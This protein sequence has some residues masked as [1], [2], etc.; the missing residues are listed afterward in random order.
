LR[1][2]RTPPFVHLLRCGTSGPARRLEAHIEQQTVLELPRMTLSRPNFRKTPTAAAI[3]AGALVLGACSDDLVSFGPEDDPEIQ[4]SIDSSKI[5][6]GQRKDGIPALTN[7]ELASEGAPGTEYLLDTDRVIGIVLD[8]E[9]IAIPLNIMWWHEI[10]NLDGAQSSVAVSHCPLTGSS[11]AFDRGNVGDSEFG[12]SG[13][14]FQTNLIMYDRSGDNESLW[15]Q[16]L[17]GARCGPSDGTPLPMVSI[18]EVTWA[19]WKWL[20]PDTKVVTSNTD[21]TRDYRSYPYGFYDR[22]SNNDL[23]FPIGQTIDSRREPKERVLGVPD[24]TGGMAFPFGALADLGDVAVVEGETSTERFVILWEAERQGA[25]AYRPVLD[26]AP[27]TMQVVNGQI[28][29]VETGSVWRMDGV[30]TNGPLDGRA[31][32]PVADAFVAF[33]FAWPA[34]YPDLELWSAS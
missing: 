8:G 9:P 11:L 2:E 20:H 18:V 24:G 3:F 15:P 16:M 4:C 29:D 28:T 5:L 21:Y 23:L 30:A 12:V 25:M 19:G 17:R 10:V 6:S 13:L 32:E 7:P 27:I 1:R 22:T 14:L 31:L 26:G 34:F 33:W